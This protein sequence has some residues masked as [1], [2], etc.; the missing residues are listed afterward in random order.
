MSERLTCSAIEPRV[1]RG[2]RRPTLC[3]RPSCATRDG[4]PYCRDHDPDTGVLRAG[5]RR[6]R[7]RRALERELADTLTKLGALERALADSQI[8]HGNTRDNFLAAMTRL[9]AA[10]HELGMP[11]HAFF[12][13]KLAWSIET[14]GPGDRAKG[15]VAHIRKELAEVEATPQSLDEWC[16]IVLL[17]MDGAARSAGADGDRFVRRLRDKQRRNTERRWPDW[18]LASPDVAIEHDRSPDGGER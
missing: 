14:F 18:R 4:R 15:V 5:R 16:D 1:I 8:A 17:A 10:E 2:E 6:R 3:G 9:R 12:D 13:A 11:F 7:S